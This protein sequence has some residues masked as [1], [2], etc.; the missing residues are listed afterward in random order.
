MDLDN[1]R[2]EVQ[3]T[4]FVAPNHKECFGYVGE[5]SRIDGF[6]EI[7]LNFKRDFDVLEENL[8]IYQP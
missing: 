1:I 7:F 5:A 2:V 6:E 4:G 3:N 8:G